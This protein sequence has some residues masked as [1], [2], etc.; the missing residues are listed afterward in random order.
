MLF[1]IFFMYSSFCSGFGSA[2]AYLSLVRA[3]ILSWFLDGMFVSWPF[4]VTLALYLALESAFFYL[5]KTISSSWA[6]LPFFRIAAVLCSRVSLL[7]IRVNAVP[8]FRIGLLFIRVKAV[9][10]LWVSTR[11]RLLAW[12]LLFVLSFT[13]VALCV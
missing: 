8:C 12:Y 4:C 9:F 5:V 2:N 11:G 13:L 6:S 7:F 3:H 1:C 10:W